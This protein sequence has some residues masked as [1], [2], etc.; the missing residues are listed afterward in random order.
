MTRDNDAALVS[1]D[2][3]GFEYSGVIDDRRA[4]VH[5]DPP[6]RLMLWHARKWGDGFRVMDLVGRFRC[7]YAG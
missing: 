5:E 7:V 6:L 3:V 4:T 1:V 2:F